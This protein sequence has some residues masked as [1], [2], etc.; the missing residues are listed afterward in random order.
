MRRNYQDM[1]SEMTGFAD[2][3]PH[4]RRKL[5]SLRELALDL[6]SGTMVHSHTQ[7]L[8]FRICLSF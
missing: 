1:A 7:I 5:A 4:G 8:F 2:P 3:V 6:I